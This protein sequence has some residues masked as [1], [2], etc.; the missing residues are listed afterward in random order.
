M[1]SLSAKPPSA[2]PQPEE[3]A[4]STR[5]EALNEVTLA[6]LII[7]GL[8]I[9]VNFQALGASHALA[10]LPLWFNASLCAGF[11]VLSYY[12]Q[13][14]FQTR[15]A[16][17]VAVLYLGAV[18]AFLIFG[19]G[20]A[21][22]AFLLAAAVTAAI[23]LGFRAGAVATGMAVVT[24]L[25]FTYLYLAT[26]VEPRLSADALN[27][28][29]AWLSIGGNLTLVFALLV[30]PQRHLWES[31][32]YVL[33][34]SRQK[35]ELL[36]TR[37]TLQK[38]T[39]QL[40][41]ASAELAGANTQLQEQSRTLE[42]RAQQLAAAAEIGR[43]ATSTFDLPTLLDT[44]VNLIRDRFGLYHASV[45][46]IE[47][48]S[49]VAELREST[50]EAGRKLKERRHKFAIGSK[51]LVGAAT[52]IRQPVIVQD[53]SADP[54]YYPDPV[55]PDTRAEAVL[56]LLR[57]D[58]VM[59]AV[60]V[61]SDTANAFAESDLAILSTITDQLAVAVQ[62]ARLYTETQQAVSEN[63]ALFKISAALSAANSLQDILAVVTQ[64]ALPKRATRASLLL[65]HHDPGGQPREVEVRAYVDTADKLQ[66]T[67]L[68]VPVA[69]LPLLTQLGSA[70]ITILDVYSDPAVDAV[71]RAT[72]ARLEIT[73][74]CI[75][76]LRSGRELIGGL[77][78]SSSQPGEFSVAELNLLRT[79]ADQVV[80]TMEK[81]R[82][83]EEA[84]RRAE[85]STAAAD[86]GRAATATFDLPTLL[87]T[88]VNL[89]RDRFGYYHASVFIV[90]PGSHV[91]EL[92][93][94]TG[95]AGRKLKERR[96]KLA[97]GSKSLVGTATATRLPVIVQDVR[98]EANYYPNPLLPDTRAEAVMPMLSGDQVIGAV[99]VQSTTPG[100]F[101][102][103]EISILSTIVGQLAVAVQNARLY[104]ETQ[105]RLTELSTLNQVSRAISSSL[106]LDLVFRAVREQL[107]QALG[108]DSMYL[109]LY[110]QERNQIS[111]PFMLERGRLIP[112]EPHTPTGRMLYILKERQ[113]LVLQG[114]AAQIAEQLQILGITSTGVAKSYLGVPLALGERAIGVLAVQDFDRAN[115]FNANHRRIL[116][117]V[118]DQL[119]VA[120]QNARLY[121]ETQDRLGELATLN[122]LSR[123]FSSTLDLERVYGIVREQV[124]G[125]MNT[126]DLTLA[127]YD[128][129]QNAVSFPFAIQRGRELHLAPR[130]PSGLAGHIIRAKE[131]VLLQG[132][133]DEVNRK[134]DALGATATDDASLSYFGVP[135]LAGQVVVG[136]LAVESFER[137][138]AFDENH[139]R[140]FT[141]V[142]DQLAVAIQNARLYA[143]TQDRLR[144]IASLNQL[145]RAFASTLEVEKVYQIVREEVASLM[146]TRDLYLALYDEVQNL[147]SFAFLIERGQELHLAP[148]PPVGLTGHIIRSKE[149]LSIQG[150]LEEVRRR[151]ESLA[152][153]VTESGLQP[154]YF[155]APLMVGQRVIGVLAAQDFERFNAFDPNKQR[156]LTTIGGQLAVTLQN[157]R[158]FAQTQAA[159]AE[160]AS[161]FKISRALSEVDSL[162]GI[163]EVIA[164]H[165][166]PFGATRA[167][168]LWMHYNEE[169]QPVEIEIRAHM[170][171]TGEHDERLGQRFPAEAGPLFQN[172]PAGPL[173]IANI[174]THPLLDPATRE[175]LR[176]LQMISACLIPLYTGGRLAAVMAASAS[177]PVGFQPQEISILRGVAEL[178]AVTLEK[179][180][181]LEETQRRAQQLA[182]AAEIGRAATASFD[183]PSIL[184]ATVNLIRE[185]FG[186]YHA[187]IFIIDPGSAMAEVRESTGEAGQ[188]LK[189]RKHRLAVGSKSLVGA[190]TA[191]RRP[192]V[193][194]DV[195]AD[196]N[197]FPNPLLPETRAEG[198]IPLVAGD[199]VVGALDVQSTRRGAFAPGDV[200]ILST[201]AGQLAVA[202]QNAR[203]Y[204]QTA[205]WANRERLANQITT[206]IRSMP[207]GDVDGMLRTAVTELRHA[208]GASHGVIQMR[209][210]ASPE[211]ADRTLEI[212]YCERTPR[213]PFFNERMANFP[214]SARALKSIYCTGDKTKC[215]RYRVAAALGA[216]QVPPDLYPDDAK[217]ADALIEGRVPQGE[218]QP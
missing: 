194:Q 167:S 118:A 104:V 37:A 2:A 21:G 180:Q 93:E 170:D 126:A 23:M 213:C 60:D 128:E 184:A 7:S 72:M 169:G 191:S 139:Q 113:P 107:V 54:S 8:C 110:D 115:T 84:H 168:L 187:S 101:L 26:P 5:L 57:G 3:T 30:V 133:L 119:A 203:L 152:G 73:S 135:L 50:G 102:Q 132:T 149:P 183:L 18:G 98:A 201:I 112:F 190:A 131:P 16:L 92:R 214:E 143:E 198:V 209:A 96:H 40:E 58:S 120:I 9:L 138:N 150:T 51:S 175:T 97:I 212:Q 47:P 173:V 42:R 218:S 17:L 210:V 55:L 108:I 155:G 144:E 46:I 66:R 109:G 136:A 114:D 166:M 20:G 88:S 189:F 105:T 1:K 89:I 215:A 179:L 13:M 59:G 85:Q 137:L 186:F 90:E 32:E 29:A 56:P 24:G 49:E 111:F 106:D 159:L 12:R 100:A 103:S 193:V 10:S 117:T 4:Q 211:P 151:F 70:P 158:L 69:D 195:Q 31:Q 78:V 165:A 14:P 197:Y 178:L 162:Q 160:N 205:R 75:L 130:P 176:R 28:W 204:D 192:V 19:M 80:V 141:T 39:R 208:L 157:A 171:L 86:I 177:L 68:R 122:R 45:F 145:S 71:T 142:A 79:V 25:G 216:A 35:Q 27:T 61:Q 36:E 129:A 34:V 33:A 196:P 44:S 199:T 62:N 65:L 161:L 206:K 185:R 182:A 64:N 125:V 74:A 153:I 52:S 53:V 217:L 95:E 140:L 67:G 6:G 164:A 188:E 94:S 202:V 200:A 146:G 156:L 83:L 81:F 207:A 82:L 121:A 15:S 123:A 134:S 172:L 147:V 63:A 181:L 124:P 11:G 38:Q 91:A 43:A 76:P 116:T 154:S 41:Q 163:L 148:R 127:L 99:D 48:G 77:L 22:A 87:E 174:D